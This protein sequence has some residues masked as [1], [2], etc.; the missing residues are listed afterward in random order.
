MMLHFDS[1]KR[2]SPSSS[3]AV[4]STIGQGHALKHLML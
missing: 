3:R 1:D 2:T 4:V